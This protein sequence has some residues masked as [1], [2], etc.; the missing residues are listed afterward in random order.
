MRDGS[1]ACPA[2]AEL[3]I[4][5]YVLETGDR[6][7]EGPGP[8]QALYYVPGILPQPN[9]EVS[10]ITHRSEPAFRQINTLMF[11]DHQPLISLPHEAL[12]FERIRELGVVV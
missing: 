9:F 5:G 1:V 8:S 10:A 7:D 12:I 6:T 11:T 3:V 4:E 2:A